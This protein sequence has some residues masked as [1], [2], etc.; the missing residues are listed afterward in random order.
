MEARS[1]RVICGR[2]ETA[3]NANHA[4]NLAAKNAADSHRS[5]SA[6]AWAKRINSSANIFRGFN[7]CFIFALSAFSA[8]KSVLLSVVPNNGTLESVNPW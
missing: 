1:R 2:I 5:T 4:K 8:V 3:K 6:A 7:P